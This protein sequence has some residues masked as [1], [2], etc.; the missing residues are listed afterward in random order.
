MTRD[1]QKLTA[2]FA[3]ADLS[4]FPNIRALADEREQVIWVLWVGR[5]K[6]TS[7][8]LSAADVSSVL[9]DVFGIH[10]SRQRVQSMLAAERRTIVPRRKGR[11][12]GYQVMQAGIDEVAGSSMATYIDPDKALSSIRKVQA[13]LSVLT[14]DIRLC[15]P[16]VDGRT[17]DLVAESKKATSVRLL[18]ANVKDVS[19]L[20]RDIKAFHRQHG[21]HLE[22]RIAQ[23]PGLHDRYAIDDVGMLM[24]GT[25]LNGIGFKQSFIVVLGPDIRSSMI[26]VFDSTWS[27][28]TAV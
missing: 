8:T 22:V 1:S 23:A 10:I 28:A 19:V 25:S 24:F 16:Y 4:G 3:A 5:D 12:T 18:T 26:P 17:L 2:A 27:Q 21:S 6:A 15:D 7:P 13:I 11:E 14:G 9:R 20:K